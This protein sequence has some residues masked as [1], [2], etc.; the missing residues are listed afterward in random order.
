MHLL[1]AKSGIHSVQQDEVPEMRHFYHS[2]KH[3]F[4]GVSRAKRKRRL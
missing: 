3:S 1:N 4:V 2:V